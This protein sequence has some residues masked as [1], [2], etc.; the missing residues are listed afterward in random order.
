MARTPEPPKLKHGGLTGLQKMVLGAFALTMAVMIGVPYIIIAVLEVP[1]IGVN[2][3]DISTLWTTIKLF[4]LVFVLVSPFFWRLVARVFAWGF[5]DLRPSNWKDS[6]LAEIARDYRN[7]HNLPFDRHLRLHTEV[8]DML[9]FGVVFLVMISALYFTLWPWAAFIDDWSD[10]W[11]ARL[12]IW[13]GPYVILFVVLI[14]DRVNWWFYDL[15]YAVI[16]GEHQSLNQA[17]A[18]VDQKA[19]AM[20]RRMEDMIKVGKPE[21][22]EDDEFAFDPDAFAKDSRPQ[23]KFTPEEER[24]AAEIDRMLFGDLPSGDTPPEH[25]D[26]GAAPTEAEHERGTDTPEH[27]PDDLALWEVVNDPSSTAEERKTA[28]GMILDREAER[29]ND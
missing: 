1:N 19:P 20:P 29:K 16:G 17:E 15:A 2:A 23:K 8:Q 18:S 4:A 7:R 9:H 12:L 27:H 10:V 28:L 14:N 11:W 25:E 5:D 24:K 3:S 13:L 6:K 26:N 21:P 22:K